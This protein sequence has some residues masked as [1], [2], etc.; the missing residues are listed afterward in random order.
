MTLPPRGYRQL[1]AGPRRTPPPLPAGFTSARHYYSLL[2]EHVLEEARVRV[3]TTSL[4]P[5]YSLHTVC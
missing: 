5:P 4:A 2:Q 1:A 3:M